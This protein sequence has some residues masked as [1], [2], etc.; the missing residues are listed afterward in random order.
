MILYDENHNDGLIEF[1]IQIPLLASRAA[2]TFEFLKSHQVLGPL[3][4]Q[5]HIADIQEK[6]SREDLLRAH[7]RRYVDSLFSDGLEDEIMRTYELLDARGDYYRYDPDSAVLPLAGLFD[8]ALASVAAT[9]DCCRS[10]LVSNFC[11][12]FSGGMHH[13]RH[14]HGAGFCLLNDIV[15]AIRKLQAENLIRTAWV[16]DT[17]AHKGDGTAALTRDDDTIAALSIHMAQGWP[18]DGAA[19]DSDGNLNPAFIPNDI[20]IPIA[21]GEEHLYVAR[22]E[23][24]L[25]RLAGFNEPDI[26][27]VVFGSDAFEKDELPSTADLRLSLEQMNQRDRLVYNFLKAR[28]IPRA[29]LM[30]GGYGEHCWQVYAQ[31]LEWALLDTCS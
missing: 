30:A 15:I 22:L 21:R 24:G 26:A 23:E 9:V 19:R 3:R 12:A 8:R 28:G 18:L 31:F 10:A 7:S 20:D 5:W 29:Y 17:D 14:D 2:Q 6:I 13:A 25:Q 16:I 1:G 11:F 4:E 27:V